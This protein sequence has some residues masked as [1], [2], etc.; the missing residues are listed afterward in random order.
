[1][2]ARAAA[3]RQVRIAVKHVPL[4]PWLVGTIALAIVVV[5]WLFASGGTSV[6]ATGGSSAVGGD[7]TNS[8]ITING[9]GTKP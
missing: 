8:P 4:T 5:V 6:T 9:G 1:M 7:V 3:E 2:A